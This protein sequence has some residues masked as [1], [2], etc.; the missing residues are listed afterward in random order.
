MREVN[1]CRGVTQS[2]A[3]VDK[4]RDSMHTDNKQAERE[5][6]HKIDRPPITTT[7]KA[8][9]GS[10]VVHSPLEKMPCFTSSVAVLY[11]AYNIKRNSQKKKKRR[12]T[13]SEKG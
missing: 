4:F 10:V 13:G 12:E 6:T 2:H 8:D 7:T 1:R 3:Q 11:R 9:F 5:E